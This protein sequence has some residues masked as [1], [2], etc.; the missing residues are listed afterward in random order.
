[1][2]AVERVAA[3]NGFTTSEQVRQFIQK[4]IDVDGYQKEA[5]FIRNIIRQELSGIVEPFGN[6]IIKMQMKIG[7]IAAGGF[8]LMLR[9]I[10]G[11][12]V[13]DADPKAFD[14][15]AKRYMVKGVE[16]MRYVKDKDADDYL[17]EHGSQ[18]LREAKNVK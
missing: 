4:G 15:F 16:Y 14:D 8:F 9:N 13:S 10:F 11:G 12:K 3:V 2:S 7:K 18:L 5:D 1:M 17:T 6:R